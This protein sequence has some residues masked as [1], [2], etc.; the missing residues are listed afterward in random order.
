MKVKE[1]KVIMVRLKVKIKSKDKKIATVHKNK[2]II[3][4]IMTKTLLLLCFAKLNKAINK[5]RN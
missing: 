2:K 5:N 3:I 4:K 1:L